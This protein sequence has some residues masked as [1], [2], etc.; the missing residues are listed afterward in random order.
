MRLTEHMKTVLTSVLVTEQAL[1]DGSATFSTNGPR[2]KQLRRRMDLADLD[3][4]GVRYDLSAW[5]GRP[6]TASD[7]AVFSRTLRRM[8]DLGLIVRVNRWGGRRT[9]HVQLTPAGRSAAECVAR[10]RQAEA[11]KLMAQLLPIEMPLGEASED[12]S[13]TAAR[14][15]SREQRVREDGHGQRTGS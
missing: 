13:D 1:R 10:Q 5:L 14:T 12:D 6:T 15:D 7:S 9:T 4:F 3:R 8:E 11:D 2:E